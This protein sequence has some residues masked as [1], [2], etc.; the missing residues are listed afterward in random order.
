MQKRE[1]LAA[2]EKAFDDC[3][4]WA[5]GTTCTQRNASGQI[6]YFKMLDFVEAFKEIEGAETL[7]QKQIEHAH[8]VISQSYWH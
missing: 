8:R 6:R 4:A 5:Q 1:I 3:G 7:T 2:L